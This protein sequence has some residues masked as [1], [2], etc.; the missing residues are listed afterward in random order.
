MFYSELSKTF[1]WTPEEID[2][3]ELEM[4]FDYVIVLSKNEKDKGQ[5]IDEVWM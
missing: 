5:Y 4:V 2:R 3:Q 1:H